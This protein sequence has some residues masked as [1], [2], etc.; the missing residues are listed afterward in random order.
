MLLVQLAE[1]VAKSW[2]VRVQECRFWTVSMV[3]LAWMNS[4]TSRLKTFV[5]NRVCQIL[6]STSIEQWSHVKTDDNPAD[7]LSRGVTP[8]EIPV[9]KPSG[10]KGH[11]GFLR[12][13]PHG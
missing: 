11:S 4:Q 8:R 1:K 10:G 6:D 7:V 2:N 13:Q 12:T 9:I 5:A 3:V